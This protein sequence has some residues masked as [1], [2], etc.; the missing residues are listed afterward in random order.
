MNIGIGY[1]SRQGDWLH[2]PV[3]QCSM[4]PRR[5]HPNVSRQHAKKFRVQIIGKN[6]R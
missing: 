2:T 5:L 3:M 1:L 4:T 6:E